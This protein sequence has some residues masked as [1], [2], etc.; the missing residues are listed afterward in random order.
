MTKPRRDDE[1]AKPIAEKP[2]G[3]CAHSAK[4]CSVRGLAAGQRSEGEP[5]LAR[6]GGRTGIL[7]VAFVSSVALAAIAVR[8]AFRLM[9]HKAV[10]AELPH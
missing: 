4:A 9:R 7:S 10:V 1:V 6:P 3:M 2:S 8:G 5:E